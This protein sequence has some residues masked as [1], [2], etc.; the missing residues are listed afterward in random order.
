MK[1]MV[2][3][4]AVVGAFLGGCSPFA[5][6][7]KNYTY[8]EEALYKAWRE[9]SSHKY[10]YDFG[11]YWE[12]PQEFEARGG[13]DCEDFAIDLVY[14]L[15][16]T[17]SAVCVLNADGGLHEIVKFKGLYLEPQRFGMYYNKKDLKILWET[18]YTDT[19]AMATLWGIKSL[20][21]TNSREHDT[22][23]SAFGG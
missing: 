16:E 22:C 21:K 2:L 6:N 14:R 11:E 9:V 1:K 18:N 20:G 10:I 4:A 8:E 3:T 7:I 13:G 12:S 23:L 19:L 17:A 15:G 5:F